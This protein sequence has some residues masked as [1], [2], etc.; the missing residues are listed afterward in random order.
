MR[1]RAVLYS[2]R[3]HYMDLDICEHLRMLC[4]HV[5]VGKVV[6]YRIGSVGSKTRVGRVT[7]NINNF[8]GLSKA[9]YLS[10][11]TE[12]KARSQ[13][14]SEKKNRTKEQIKICE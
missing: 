9:H 3:V 14:K 7:G 8:L 1:R 10:S 13:K 12:V 6:R 11:Q 5:C 2:P 4:E